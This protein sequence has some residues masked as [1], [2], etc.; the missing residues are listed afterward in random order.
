VQ[1]QYN[2]TNRD[3]EP[4]LEQCEANNLAFIPYFPLAAGNL[5]EDNDPLVEIPARYDAT[6]AQLALAW[7]L[8][9]SPNILVI[10]GTSSVKHLE[11]NVEAAAIELSTDAF[12]ALSA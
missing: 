8:N 1:N 2:C 10:P 6:P 11:E 9:R 12:K 3:S 7:L 4:V 5:T